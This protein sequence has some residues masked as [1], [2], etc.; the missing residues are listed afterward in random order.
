[1]IVPSELNSMLNANAGLNFRQRFG[2][3]IEVFWVGLDTRYSQGFFLIKVLANL[4]F[5]VVTNQ[6]QPGFDSCNML[7]IGIA[8]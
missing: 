6:S 3:T 4:V 8:F 5:D 1:M 7:R 2:I